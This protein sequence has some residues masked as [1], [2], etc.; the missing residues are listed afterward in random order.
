MSLEQF[1]LAV[2]ILVALISLLTPLIRL[3]GLIT[4]LTALLDQLSLRTAHCEERIEGLE[5]R[6]ARDESCAAAMEE[7]VRHLQGRLDRR[8]TRA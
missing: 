6:L 3:N 1:S 7:A 2:G 4:R 5:A 8:D